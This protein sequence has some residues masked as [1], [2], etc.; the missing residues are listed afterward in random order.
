MNNSTSKAGLI[1]NIADLLRGSWK[2]YEYQ[3]VILP[4]VVLKRLDSILVDSKSKVLEQYNQFKGKVDV[5]PVLKAV[6]KTGFYNISQ[7]DLKKLLEDPKNV[8]KNLRN[9][10]RGFS[11]NIQEI[12]AK[13]DF[14]KQI[15]RLEGGNL[16]F[17]VLK[18][19]DKVD[20]HPRTTTNHDMGYVFEELIR[21]FA[22]QSNETAG[23]HYTPREV[24]EMMVEVLFLP[25]KKL[26][27]KKHI[28]KTIYDCACGTGGM[29]TTSKEHIL[30]TI[31]PE[32]DIYLFG[33][34]LNPATYAICKSDMLIKGDD[35]DRIKGGDKDHS[36]SSTLSNDQFLSEHFDYLLTNPPFGVDWKKDKEA[37]EREAE[38]GF[39]GRFGAGLPR[40]SD[41][42]FLFL[43]HLISKMRNVSEGGSRTAIVFNGSPLFT[44]DAGSG[45]SEIRRW[46]LEH[47]WL[48]AIVALPDQLFYNTGINTYVW[49]LTNRK[50]TKRKGKV[51][52]ID[53]RTF[54]KK[55]RKSL[56][57]KRNE[58]SA[59][60]KKHILKL[61][62]SF[63][64]SEYSKIFNNTDFAFRQITIERPLRLA[65]NM[66][67]DK[68]IQLREA[69]E[70]DLKKAINKSVKAQ[71]KSEEVLIMTALSSLQGRKWNNREK[72]LADIEI[73]FAKHNLKLQPKI[74][75]T[76]IGV[77]G[78]R[79]EKAEICVDKN[80]QPEA[81][82]ELRDSENVPYH[83]DVK[84]YFAKEVKPFVS[85]AWINETV[86]DQ[87]DGKLGKVGYEIPL[88][89]YFYKYQPPRALEEIESDIEGVENELLELLKKL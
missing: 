14:E 53:A 73:V 63:G 72:F 62:E 52:L 61:Y 47:D 27:K 11:D 33:Q 65:F 87:K 20:L 57:N 80:G 28:I 19:L 24:I 30:K 58:I 83:Q 88:T 36:K 5:D 40:I 76:I 89:R 70:I 71:T 67:S 82:S 60:D 85:D 26:L 25:D 44:G 21:K 77:I 64:E 1:W 39:A 31:N 4:L 54:S 50:E 32:A 6:T 69:L 16:L 55:M 68:I 59:E 84:E 74:L 37:V 15:D 78:F 38:R 23:E 34:E 10:I 42:Q 66:S 8:S 86:K 29:L 48:E 2:Q 49:F 22:E 17:L 13:F 35:P 3:D 18:E 56:G 45:E 75:K 41:G 12:I 7:Y 79:D 46:I 43:Q 51:Q 81:D 9:Y